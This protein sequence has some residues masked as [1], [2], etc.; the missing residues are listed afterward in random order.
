MKKAG[1]AIQIQVRQSKEQLGKEMAESDLA[2]GCGQSR[3]TVGTVPGWEGAH[4][5]HELQHECAAPPWAQAGSAR[6]PW[7]H[8][9]WCYNNAFAFSQVQ[10]FNLR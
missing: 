1:R 2:R 8:R 4:N 5:T 3:E 7:P 9:A 10:R 6:G